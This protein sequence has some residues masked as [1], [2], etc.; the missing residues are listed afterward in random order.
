MLLKETLEANRKRPPLHDRREGHKKSA[1]PQVLRKKKY[2][3]EEQER[4][5]KKHRFPGSRYGN[6]TKYGTKGQPKGG[7]YHSGTGGEDT[8]S[9]WLP[10]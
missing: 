1:A 4:E 7:N 6:S 10:R 9:E 5:K 8:A 2:K 3:K